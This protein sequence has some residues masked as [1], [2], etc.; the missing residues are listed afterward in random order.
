MSVGGTGRVRRLSFGSQGGDALGHRQRAG[1]DA[2]RPADCYL[3][4]W[5]DDAEFAGSYGPVA[6]LIDDSIN[7]KLAAAE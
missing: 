2:R 6:S 7:D 4:A 1:Y 5:E 3:C